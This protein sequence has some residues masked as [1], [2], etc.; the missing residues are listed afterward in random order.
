MNSDLEV[1]KASLAKLDHRKL[2]PVLLALSS[3]NNNLAQKL[4]RQGLLRPVPNLISFDEWANFR[5]T[6]DLDFGETDFEQF[7]ERVY[8]IM[9]AAYHVDCVSS[10][11]NALNAVRGV[12]GNVYHQ[13]AAKA[14]QYLIEERNDK[15]IDNF[16]NSLENEPTSQLIPYME[17]FA[18]MIGLKD[19]EL[20]SKMLTFFR[21]LQSHENEIYEL[22]TWLCDNSK[23]S[24]TRTSY[25]MEMVRAC[26]PPAGEIVKVVR[27]QCRKNEMECLC[28]VLGVKVFFHSPEDVL[29]WKTEPTWFFE[30]GREF[31]SEARPR[32]L[33]LSAAGVCTDLRLMKEVLCDLSHQPPSNVNEVVRN[34]LLKVPLVC[35]VYQGL[36]RNTACKDAVDE[37]LFWNPP[38]F[39]FEIEASGGPAIVSMIEACEL[40]MVLKSVLPD[41]IRDGYE[42][43]QQVWQDLDPR[44]TLYNQGFRTPV[45]FSDDT[46]A[47]RGTTAYDWNG[48]L[49]NYY[50][51]PKYAQ[52]FPRPLGESS[53]NDLSSLAARLNQALQTREDATKIRTI[54][55]GAAAE[56]RPPAYEAHTASRG[57]NE[58]DK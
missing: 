57:Q 34:L 56:H 6:L 27:E 33:Q 31:S 50:R 49:G 42:P 4:M 17:C 18:Y 21:D 29:L 26:D 28:R 51:D 8:L 46:H 9:E 23:D 47:D 25:I 54:N 12:M 10:F 48:H 45:I 53:R 41:Y 11:P 19:V 39:E 24:A 36:R 44:K 37:A 22:I 7:S 38:A 14:L 32:I 20:E 52:F 13:H 30:Y 3:R 35:A 1:A 55:A 43:W 40:L 2:Q 15:A 58:N 5:N 16:L